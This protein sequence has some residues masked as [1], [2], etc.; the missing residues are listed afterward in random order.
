MSGRFLTSKGQSS[1]EFFLVVGI[2]IAVS[3]PFILAAQRSVVNI[4]QTQEITTLQ[5]S[6]DRMQEAVNTVSV[7]G[8][9]ARRTFLVNLPDSVTGAQ[10]IQDTAVVYTVR[11]GSDRVNL[12]RVFNTNISAPDGL[13]TESGRVT[14]FA[15]RGQVNITEVN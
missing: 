15:W 11:R 14:V 13:P 6:L 12:T 7:S 2:A 5:K 10:V 4:Q 3:T 8:A 1:L 9:P